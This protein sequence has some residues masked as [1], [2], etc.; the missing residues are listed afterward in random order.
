MPKARLEVTTTVETTTTVELSVKA[1]KMLLERFAE[2][3][4]LSGEIDV[5]EARRARIKK[6]VDDIFAKEGQGAALI[7]GASIE[8]NKAV[9]VCGSQTTLDEA[10]LMRDFDITPAQFA[11]YKVTKEKKPY[12]KLTPAGKKE[13]A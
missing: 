10:A 2:D 6:E 7:D 8:G 12:L 1:K 9:W 13:K 3:L 11:A 4:K 5:K